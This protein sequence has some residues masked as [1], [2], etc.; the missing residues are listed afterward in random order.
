MYRGSL[1]MLQIIASHPQVTFILRIN[2]YHC[3]VNIFLDIFDEIYDLY[4]IQSDNVKFATYRNLKSHRG[5]CTI[6]IE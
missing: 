2:I 1:L 3:K 5:K 4:M 6:F